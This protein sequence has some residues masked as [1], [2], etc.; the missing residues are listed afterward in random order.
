L[1][2]NTEGMDTFSR[3]ESEA[4]LTLEDLV[5]NT[6]RMR[7]DRVIIGEVR[8]KEAR[9]MMT[10]M[11]IGKYCMATIH[12]A[13]TKEAFAR[14]QH[15]PMNIDPAMIN[16]IDIFVVLRKH[17]RIDGSHRVL[18]EVLETAVLEHRRPLVS[19]LWKY[20][21]KTKETDEVM[22]CTVFREKLAEAT[23]SE[24]SV[25]LNE[26]ERRTKVLYLL[27]KKKITTIAELTHFFTLYNADKKKAIE[28]LGTTLRELDKMSHRSLD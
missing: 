11:N 27:R 2:L 3:L 21:N 19:V 5:K 22:P 24:P 6:L 28:S 10:A 13:N 16:L 9:D 18:E 15:D 4:N 20:N 17:R 25:V 1:E 8:G 12:A 23:G 14:L 26:W 7:P